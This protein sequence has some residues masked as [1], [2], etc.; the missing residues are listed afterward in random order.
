MGQ[1]L[2]DHKGR[3]VV[4]VTGIGVVSSLGEGKEDNW[5]NLTSG[6]SGIRRISRFSTEELHTTISGIIDWRGD[7]IYCAP[8]HSISLAMKSAKEAISQANI[9]S[10]GSFPGPLYAAV[11]PAE[12]NWN[13]RLVLFA[14]AGESDS[15]GHVRIVEAAAKGN[16]GDYYAH[17]QFG[18]ISEHLADEL[19]T[20]GQPVSLTT[21]CASGATAI[22]LGVEAIRRG[23]TDAALCLGTDGSICE[24][25][26]VR[27]SLLS[28]LSTQNDSPEEASKP[29][30]KNRDGFVM[31][32]G[33]ATLVLESYDSA[34][35]RGAKILGVVRGTGEQADTFHRTRSKPDG[36]AIIGTLKR[37]MN[38]AGM[39]PADID[40]INA[41][42]TST[43]E[44]DKMEFLSLSEALGGEL[45]NIPISS[46]KSMIGHTLI[47]A[48]AI[49][50]AFSILTINSG[51]IPP[52]INCKL[53]DPNIDMDV[54]PNVKREMAVDTVL[55]NSFGFGGQNVCFLFS[56]GPE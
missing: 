32:E 2:K 44:N 54:V 11:S 42:G 33:S 51:T 4:V 40:Y 14:A 3:P 21:A 53:Q 56:G 7:G 46:N 25:M 52:T 19:G 1:T 13:Q 16:Y 12:L 15:P 47:A 49:E 41:H 5:K 37:T 20:R 29:F 18:S 6:I 28:A 23:D 50:A 30:S 8:A 27:F 22:Q 34:V 9:G 55:S 26:V 38:D 45:D 36:S 48:G 24:E 10:P 17:Y 31:A 39:S 35:A 43:P